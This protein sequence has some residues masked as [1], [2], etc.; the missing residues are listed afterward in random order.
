MSEQLSQDDLVL[1][2]RETTAP[3]E[4]AALLDLD[5][6]AVVAADRRLRWQS[7]LVVVV[8]ALVIALP[9]TV[10]RLI[11][12]SDHV[13]PTEMLV[14]GLA[15]FGLLVAA[16]YLPALL[17]AAPRL[18]ALSV[19]ARR[20]LLGV[21]VEALLVGAIVLVS[22]LSSSIAWLT[23]VLIAAIASQALSVVSQLSLKSALVKNSR[24]LVPLSR[25]L[26]ELPEWLSFPRDRQGWLISA[27][28]AS[29]FAIAGTVLLVWM[30]PS[31]ALGALVVKVAGGVITV[32]A[33]SHNR[34]R[35]WIGVQIVAAALLF[36]A[37]VA[38]FTATA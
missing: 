13:N 20:L 2:L 27:L 4:R 11:A 31:L 23:G 24:Q 9:V 5:F 36:G 19:G 28:V 8:A 18:R 30:T 25:E 22:A 1:R 26:T 7:R 35:I 3:D 6:G 16:L 34:P 10:P 12:S 33:A 38:A 37:G 32:W 14:S 29:A 15:A 21:A 17:L